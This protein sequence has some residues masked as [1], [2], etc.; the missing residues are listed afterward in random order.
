[1]PVAWPESLIA[2]AIGP[3]LVTGIAAGIVGGFVGASFTAGVRRPRIPAPL[4]AP[5]AA[6]LVAIVV[7]FGLNVGDRTPAGWSGQVSLD[8]VGTGAERHVQATVRLDPAEIGDDAYWLSAI[9]WQGGGLVVNDLEQVGPGVYQSTKP[10]PVY[11]TWKTLI[12]LQRDNYVAGVPIYLPE[13]TAIP[14]PRVPAKASF[15]RPFVD[16]TEILQREQKGDVPGYLTA[17]A[18]GVVALIVVG[19]VLL[20]GWVLV[21][22]ASDEQRPRR[23]PAA[24]PRPGARPSTA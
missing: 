12:R 4:I 10:L 18:Y 16:E 15:E 14:A 11:G 17:L 9:S 20:L 7:A 6:A 13:D 22:I 3:V 1:M 21:R 23:E 24:S 19:L 5:A 8:D 2:E